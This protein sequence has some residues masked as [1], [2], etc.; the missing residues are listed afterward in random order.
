M[1][2]LSVLVL[3]VIT[4]AN[5]LPANLLAQTT[6][7]D[8]ADWRIVGGTNAAAGAYPFVVS[9]RSSS[10]SHFCGGSILNTRWVLTASHCII[11]STTAN[12]FVYAGSNILNSG[13]VTIPTSRLTLHSNYDHDIAA[14]DVAVIQLANA[15]TYSNTIAPVALNIGETGAVAAI[16][17]GWGRISTNGAIPNNLQELS[18]NTITHTICRLSWGS[19]VSSDQICAVARSGQGACSG[20]SGGPLIQASNNVQLGVTSFIRAGGCAQGFPDVYARVSSY[21]S[22]IT[23][24]LSS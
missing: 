15:L 1:F 9:L 18:T 16:L 2:K 24:A 22:W 6:I 5:A 13:G 10:N 12:V 20:D 11:G 17:I 21:N 7:D 4:Y 19:L 3:A 23:N 8:A 14:N